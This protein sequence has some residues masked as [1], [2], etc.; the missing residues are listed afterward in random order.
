MSYWTY[1][2]IAI[3]NQLSIVIIDKYDQ[4]IDYKWRFLMNH[5]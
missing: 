2:D 1:W 5:P 4:I 3:Y